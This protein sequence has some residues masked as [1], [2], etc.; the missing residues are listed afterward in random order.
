MELAVVDLDV[1]EGVAVGVPDAQGLLGPARP[2][3]ERPEAAAKPLS[4]TRNAAR[5]AWTPSNAPTPQAIA[6]HARTCQ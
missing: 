1:D 2:P 3:P 4:A 6:Q 5:P